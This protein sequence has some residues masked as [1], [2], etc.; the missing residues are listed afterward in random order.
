MNT[1]GAKAEIDF[2]SSGGELLATPVRGR[3]RPRH[4][5]GRASS[6]VRF[7]KAARKLAKLQGKLLATPSDSLREES[8]KPKRPRQE[9]DLSPFLRPCSQ[10]PKARPDESP[11]TA[12]WSEAEPQ[13]TVNS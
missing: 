3:G 2:D 12:G 8:R 10:A 7:P 6:P 9:I 11:A 5:V 1:A 13:V 4:N